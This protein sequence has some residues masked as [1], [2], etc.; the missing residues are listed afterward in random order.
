[1]S[2]YPVAG[3][4]QLVDQ[5]LRWM[6]FNDASWRIDDTIHPF[7]SSFSVNDVRLTTR[8]AEHYFPTAL[9]SAMHE[10]GHGL[11][12]AG[13][14]PELQRTP[15]GTIRSSAIHES[16]S[17]LWENMV[18]RGRAFSTALAPARGGLLRRSADRVA[19]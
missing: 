13:I 17:R 9:Y 10:C 14:A 1:M 4:R 19:A 6:G 3:Q 12:E 8:Y 16:Q 15:L 5:V 18:G 11:Y 7:E 2:T